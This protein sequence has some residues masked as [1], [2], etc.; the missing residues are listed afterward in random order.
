MQ[1]GLYSADEYGRGT[2]QDSKTIGGPKEQPI[3]G[4]RQ[5]Q[6]SNRMGRPYDKNTW[7]K[8]DENA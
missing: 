8:L 2:W 4:K 7:Q 5:R 6:T 1:I 3:G